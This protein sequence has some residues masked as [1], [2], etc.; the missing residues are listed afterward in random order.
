MVMERKIFIDNTYYSVVSFGHGPKNLTII[1]GVSLAGIEGSGD[2]VAAA[3]EM[4]AEDYTIYLYGRRNVL[5]EGFTVKD[6]A[7]D[8]NYCMEELGVKTSSVYGV[9]QG[10]MIAQCLAIHHPEKVEKLALA[11]TMCKP[12]PMLKNIVPIWNE[13]ATK[14]DVVA[15]NRLFF[16]YCYSEAFLE[17]VKEL[18]PELE[19]VG[20]AED[21]ERFLVQTAACLSFNCSDEMDKILCPVL[22]I[23]DKNDQVLGV[24]GS[25]DIIERIKCESKIYDR[26]SHAIYDECP[27]VKTILK[28]FLDR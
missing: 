22:V 9:S 21:C 24:E 28:E 6:M 11:S 12:T 3:Y 23:G 14:K 25:Y 7:E 2:A 1:A 26:Y 10:G 20:T 8:V 15:L 27:E 16:R 19:K 17:S 5:P 18:L 13:A 4:F